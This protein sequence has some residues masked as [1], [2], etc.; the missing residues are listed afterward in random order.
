MMSGI[1]LAVVATV[2]AATSA[3]ELPPEKS[4]FYEDV[5]VQQQFGI[6]PDWNK[7]IEMFGK[8][9]SLMSDNLGDNL[10]DNVEAAGLYDGSPFEIV[11]HG[12]SSAAS[13]WW[14]VHSVK[15]DSKKITAISLNSRSEI[16]FIISRL[17]YI[18]T[19]VLGMPS[20]RMHV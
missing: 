2:I 18:P 4:K 5:S 9:F 7:I 11:Y 17:V 20:L 14:Y 15:A 1:I 6:H 13:D 12:K 8:L 3:A 19:E 16:M 10:G